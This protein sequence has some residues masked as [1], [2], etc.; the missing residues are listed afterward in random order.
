M[1]Q[2]QCLFETG[3][4]IKVILGNK[5]PNNQIAAELLSSVFI[6]IVLAHNHLGD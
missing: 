3:N 5:P 6:E 4:P 2:H 1:C